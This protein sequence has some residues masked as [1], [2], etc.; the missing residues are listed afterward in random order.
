M[1]LVAAAVWIAVVLAWPDAAWAL[2]FDDSFYYFELAKRA[3]AGEGLTFDGR[4]ATNGFHPL[5]LLACLPLAGLDGLAIARAA[6]VGQAVLFGAAWEGLRRRFD[7]PGWLVALAIVG[8][9]VAKTWVNGMESG[10]VLP[11]HAALLTWRGPR[12]GWAILATLA[13]FARTD[14]GF[15][16]LCAGLWDLRK[17]APLVEK[18]LLPGLAILAF[19]AANQALFGTPVQVSGQLKATAASPAR[20]IWA[21][22]VCAIPFAV[23]RARLAD[24]PAT[25]A[26][27]HETG[28][29][30]ASCCVLVAYYTGVQTFPRLWYF[31]P[32]VLY[33]ILLLGHVAKDLFAMGEREG[34]PY[35]VRAVIAL[36]LVAAL[37]PQVRALVDPDATAVMRADAEAGRW[38]GEQLPPDAVVGSWDAGVIGWFAPQPVVNLDGVVNDVA[39]LRAMREGTTPALLADLTHVCNHTGSLA[40]LEAHARAI[41]G[42]R[43]TRWTEVRRWEYA[44]SGRTQDG[45]APRMTTVCFSLPR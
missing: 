43:A 36:P 22:V 27:L 18:Y 16:L 6:L 44:F 21:I 4:H 12:W 15:L 19:M 32:V 34:R 37:V 2:T 23:A 10:L 20:A 5:W 9:S 31:G 24:L 42:E 28:W 3:V 29:Y 33:G 11:L 17:R 14:A 1:P 30:G 7:L 25:R 40:T 8:P 39:Y 45:A 13:F 38:I 41:V 26:F 35:A